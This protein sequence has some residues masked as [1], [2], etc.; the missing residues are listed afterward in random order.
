M[1]RRNFFPSTAFARLSA[2]SGRITSPVFVA[3]LGQAPQDGFTE[4]L[5]FPG[6]LS[7]RWGDYSAAVYAPGTGKIYFANE[8]I[9]FPACSG[10]AFTLTLGT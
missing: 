2:F 1:A 9:P 10:P 3:D 8:Y 5:G 4:Y 6:P 7:Q